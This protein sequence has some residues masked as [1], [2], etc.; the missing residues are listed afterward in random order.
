[1]TATSATFNV[2]LHHL[3]GDAKRADASLPDTELMGITSKQLGALL[4][5]LAKLAPTVAYPTAPELRI[6]AAEGRFL[7]QVKEGR[8]R[9][10]SW[11]LRTG[12]SELTPAQILAAITGD[13]VV[14]AA[15]FSDGGSSGGGR[16]RRPRA[17]VIALLALVIVGSNAMTAWTLTRPAPD[18][19]PP[20]RLLEP[21][22]AQRLLAEVAGTYETG[23]AEGDRRLVIARD[24]AVQWAKFGAGRALEEETAL[25]T[26]GAQ[27]DGQPALL[28]SARALIEIK[29]PLTLVY[30]GDTYRRKTP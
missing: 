28:T 27:S 12:G 23:G 8:I 9:F 20:Y 7:V 4:A 16:K 5:A 21:E 18:L 22:P 29:D 26:Q 3:A 19:L 13:D 25:T 10:T 17:A 24:G 30:Y 15:E 2:T 6:A 11:A 1:M 14:D